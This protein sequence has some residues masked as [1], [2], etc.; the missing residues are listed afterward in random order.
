LKQKIEES[1]NT[2]RFFLNKTL[3]LDK[4]FI[5]YVHSNKCAGSSRHPGQCVSGMPY[6]AG[7]HSGTTNRKCDSSVFE[8]ALH[9]QPLTASRKK[10]VV[11]N[12]LAQAVF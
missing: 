4:I 3:A 5:P 8:L 11:V 10:A 9:Q 7:M 1:T 12:L 2:V 6:S